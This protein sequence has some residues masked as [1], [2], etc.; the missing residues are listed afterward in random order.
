MIWE[1]LQITLK[2]TC[3]ELALFFEHRISISRKLCDFI[4]DT[5]R[6]KKETENN[7]KRK[8]VTHFHK[9]SNLFWQNIYI[10]CDYK[11]H[12][13]TTSWIYLYLL[14]GLS[15]C[16]LKVQFFFFYCFTKQGLEQLI[17]IHWTVSTFIHNIFIFQWSNYILHT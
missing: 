13:L 14:T 1:I 5:N 17:I 6:F 11:F 2:N 8:Q 7:E 10:D 12:S 15:Y 16:S 9:E 3:L 4:R